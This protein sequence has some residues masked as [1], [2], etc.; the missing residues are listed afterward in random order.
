MMNTVPPN[1]VAWNNVSESLE[2]KYQSTAHVDGR[3]DGALD[4]GALHY[5]LG[6]L[7]ERRLDLLRN[8]LSTLVGR[9]LDSPDTRNQRLGHFQSTLIEIRDHYRSST[10]RM[11]GKK[12][13]NS[14][15]SSAAYY[16]R[17]TETKA[18]TLNASE[19][20][21]KWFQQCTL[22]VRHIV[23]DAVEPGF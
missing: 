15:G 22:F 6:F 9:D 7:S 12:S 16:E 2:D 1:L 20:H 4:A 5:E 19:S 8:I 3:V 11:S 21:R 14:Y 18:R 10:G 13:D 23:R 17:I